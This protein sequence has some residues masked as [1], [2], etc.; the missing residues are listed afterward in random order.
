[1]GEALWTSRMRWRLRGATLWPAFAVA[2]VVDAVLLDVLPIS[3]DDGPGLFAT[4]IL[5]G[6]LN[7]IVVA[8]AAPLAGH[9]L[10][11][12]RPD[13]PKVVA[14]DQAGTVLLVVVAVAVAALGL[15]HRPAV[16][17]A[18]ADLNAQAG[19]ARSFALVHAPPQY[20]SQIGHLDTWKQNRDLYRTCVPGPDP[21]RAFCM[22]V[23]TDRSPPSIVIDHDQRPNG[24]AAGTDG[25]ARH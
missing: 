3:G 23:E 14:T 19:L 1:M 12:R 18:D 7:L 22:I 20:R 8:V 6:F 5:A 21:R 4:V 16:R 2:V 17:A 13:K 10:R 15:L 11:Q 9:L 24:T 25:A